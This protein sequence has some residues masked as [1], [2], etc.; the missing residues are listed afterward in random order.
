M[1][2]HV[3]KQS[4][5]SQDDKSDIKS[6]LESIESMFEVCKKVFNSYT[7]SA[8]ML[9]IA[10]E[11]E[12]LLLKLRVMEERWKVH[13][14][15]KEASNV[16]FYLWSKKIEQM[17]QAIGG[18][19]AAA[20]SEYS[21]DEYCPSKHFML[22]L[23]E[24]LDESPSHNGGAAYYADPNVSKFIAE[25]TRIRRQIIRKWNHYRI[26]F[27][28]L[29]ARELDEHIGDVL[30]PLADRCVNIKMTCYTILRD[31]STALYNL[32]DTPKGNISRDQFTR[33]AERVVSE[34]E[35]GGRKAMDT[36]EHE[37]NEAKN[38][39][40]EDQW[41]AR[42]EDEIRVSLELIKDLKLGNKVFSFLGRDKTM[43]DNS[44]GLG[45]F[46]WS[47]RRDI[48]NNDLY[49][50]IELLYRMAYLT[51]EREQASVAEPVVQPTQS[52]SKDAV[53]V[54]NNRLSTKP[55]SPRLPNFFSERLTGNEDAV[56]CYYKTL[57]HCG[58]YIGRTLLEHEKKNEDTSCYTGWKWKH[59]REAFVKLDIIK[60]DSSKKGFA[61]HLSAVFPC[62]EA[63][64]IQRGFNSRGGYTDP[65]ATKRIIAD[66]VSE[67]KEVADLMKNEDRLSK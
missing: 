31:L 55:R 53:A 56:K 6:I 38:N 34:D 30:K 48:S 9:S 51:K 29:V 36:V 33:L 46:L 11:A 19:D 2:I 44:A 43:L 27:S 66:M 15:F 13:L 14:P 37:V 3:K 57:H 63:T 49:N 1:S 20:D 40:P 26:Q 12:M 35:Y 7:Q 45:R 18:A 5:Q 24:C 8:L 21:L 52:E 4:I 59:L 64:N 10:T 25:Q 39:T 54:Y 17:A 47:V 61:E 23:Y 16:D 58:F 67:F 41:D 60:T 65:V 28:G 22:D 32:Y 42:R 50:L 62:L